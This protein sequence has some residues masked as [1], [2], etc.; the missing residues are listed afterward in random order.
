MTVQDRHGGEYVVQARTKEVTGR[1]GTLKAA[2]AIQG[3]AVISVASVD[4]DGQTMAE[5]RRD[6]TILAIMQ[7]LSPLFDNPFLRTIWP[8]NG[9]VVWPAETFPTIDTPPPLSY[10]YPLNESQQLA[11]ES[12]LSL[13]NDLRILL[14]Q[15]PPGTGKTTVIGAFVQ[16]AVDSGWTG[17]WLLAQSNV[18]VKNIAE[19][20]AKI[21]FD[22]W[23]LLVSKDFHLGW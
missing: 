10:Q 2:G 19:K 13:T 18:A 6:A 1:Q 16:S 7:G 9:E 3:K 11:V 20:L 15:G 12:M 22:D 5:Q 21:G 4:P 17:I 8:D 14:I 23:K